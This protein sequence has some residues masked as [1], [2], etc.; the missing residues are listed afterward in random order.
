MGVF[1][2]MSSKGQIRHKGG[3]SSMVTHM[4]F[5]EK[6]KTGKLLLVNTE[7]VKKS[8]QEFIA[9]WRALIAYE[10]KLQAY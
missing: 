8:V 2:G 9:I 4:F 7:L 5:Y 10:N 1:M 3:D 6:T